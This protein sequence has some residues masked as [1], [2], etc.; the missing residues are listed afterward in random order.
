M[1][2]IFTF[3]YLRSLKGISTRRRSGQSLGGGKKGR[4]KRREFFPPLQCS[5]GGGAFFSPPLTLEK[6][7]VIIMRFAFVCLCACVGKPFLIFIRLTKF[8]EIG[9][10]FMLLETI[11]RPHVLISC[12]Y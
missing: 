2:F 12:N 4:K 5:G 10:N 9:M 6:K 11:P 8:Y 1:Y 7:A 3:K